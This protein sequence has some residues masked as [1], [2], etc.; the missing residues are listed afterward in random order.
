MMSWLLIA[1]LSSYECIG[2]ISIQDEYITKEECIE[3]KQFLY[4]L[5]GVSISNAYCVEIQND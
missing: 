4:Q 1:V 5:D 3:A 2:G